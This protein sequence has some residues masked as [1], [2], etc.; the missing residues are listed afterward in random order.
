MHSW[1][2][3]DVTEGAKSLCQRVLRGQPRPELRGRGGPGTG[4]CRAPV[5]RRNV[6]EAQRLLPI[7]RRVLL[8]QQV[9]AP[10]KEEGGRQRGEEELSLLGEAGPLPPLSWELAAELLQTSERSRSGAAWSR[11]WGNRSVPLCAARHV[12]EPTGAAR[13]APHR[14]RAAFGP[15]PG[16]AAGGP[17]GAPRPPGS[18]RCSWGCG[19]CW[20]AAPRRSTPATCAT[21]RGG[22]ARGRKRGPP[23]VPPP[24]GE[25][26]GDNKRAKVGCPAGCGEGAARGGSGAA[27]LSRP[28]GAAL[29]RPG[30]GRA[31]AAG[32]GSLLPSGAVG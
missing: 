11:A 12:G 18:C 27:L 6:P 16:V 30:Q 28:C 23:L 3:G 29:E 10:P 21:G 8:E 25:S 7:R 22:E 1:H 4:Q 9:P 26:G 32:A 15:G 19:C 14:S 20:A 5:P 31:G 13:I 2:P 17:C 24:R